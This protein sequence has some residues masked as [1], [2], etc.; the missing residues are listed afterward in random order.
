MIGVRIDSAIVTSVA[1][2]KKN[3]NEKKDGTDTNPLEPQL[4][5]LINNQ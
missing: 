1:L 4:R 3:G 5:P 2:P